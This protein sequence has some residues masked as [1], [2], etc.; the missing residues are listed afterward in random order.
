MFGIK[1]F[2]VI[3]RIL[4]N[5]RIDPNA[6]TSFMN[7]GKDEEVINESVPKQELLEGDPINRRFVRHFNKH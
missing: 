6:P 4:K 7:V 5:K 1:A 2:R 3:G